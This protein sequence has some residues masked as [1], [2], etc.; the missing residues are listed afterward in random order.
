LASPEKILIFHED[1]GRHNA[2]DMICGQCL[3]DGIPTEDKLIVTTGRIA[4]EI[5]LKAIRLGVPVLASGSAA[6]RFAID[7][8]RKTNMTLVGQVEQGHMIVFNNGGRINL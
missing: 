1:I 3:L 5:L 2:I 8:A 6:T 7:L 4:S